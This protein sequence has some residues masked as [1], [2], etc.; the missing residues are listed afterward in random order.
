MPLT[1]SP[2]TPIPVRQAVSLI[3]QWVDRLG[4]VWVEGQVTQISRRGGMGT[5]FLVLRDK[6]ADVS[7]TLTAPRGVVDSL[8][9][10]L[11]EGAQIVVHAANH[12]R[13]IERPSR[14]G[15]RRCR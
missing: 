3:G 4:V 11:V 15:F 14:N 7:M 5:V 10:P 6:L 2:E 13:V 9:T 1:T 8:P 12:K